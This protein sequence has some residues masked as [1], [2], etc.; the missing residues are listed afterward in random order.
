MSEW[1]QQK[2]NEN[3]NLPIYI[4]NKYEWMIKM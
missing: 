1:K 2:E 3:K 4:W